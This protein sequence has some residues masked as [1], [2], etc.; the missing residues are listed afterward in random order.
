MQDDSEE[1]K[2]LEVSIE[3]E[4]IAKAYSF[5]VLDPVFYYPFH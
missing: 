2:E 5:R 3:V 4:W 1:E